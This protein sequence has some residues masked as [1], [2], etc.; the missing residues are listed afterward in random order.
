MT[1]EQP[2][3][4]VA[5][6]SPLRASGSGQLSLGLHTASL[7]GHI[8]CGSSSGSGHAWVPFTGQVPLSPGP[9]RRWD[10]GTTSC[11][12]SPHTGTVRRLWR[13]GWEGKHWEDHPGDRITQLP[14]SCPSFGW[15][16]PCRI[17]SWNK[18]TVIQL[19][20]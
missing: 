17:S 9:E 12:L 7:V 19:H 18:T 3:S 20:N 16:D 14:R 4:G 13:P 2:P 6:S 5:G 11:T 1:S 8:S 15:H 10:P